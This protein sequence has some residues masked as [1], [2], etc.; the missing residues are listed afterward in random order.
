MEILLK[1]IVNPDNTKTSIY[2][3][4][5]TAPALKHIAGVDQLRYVFALWV[6]FTHGGNP[7]LFAGHAKTPIFDFID[8]LYGWSVNGQ[9]AVMGFFIVS[10]LCIHYPNIRRDSFDIKSFYAARFLRL[11][12]PLFACL[13]IAKFLNFYHPNGFLRVVP[14]W[15]LYCEAIYYVV[16]PFVL[17][18]VKKDY[19]IQL[20]I[21]T[22]FLSVVLI[23]IWS[24][25]RSMYF[26]EIGGGGFLNWKA[27]LL[28][29]PCWLLGVLLAE[30]L[31]VASI[32]NKIVNEK[33]GI[34]LWRTGAL[35]LSVITFPLYRYALYYHFI[36]KPIIGLF[37]TSQLTILL[38]GLY[39]F[40]WIE[41]EVININ[42]GKALPSYRLEKMGAASYSLYL[43]HLLVI[44]LF[45]KI[46]PVYFSGYLSNWLLLFVTLHIAVF[47]F[48]IV[49]EKPSHKL[50]K[51]CAN[52]LRN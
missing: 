33:H 13:A 38:F 29:F 52:A 50:S 32:I 4:K 16:Y 49:F 8:H 48:F 34:W 7:P 42:F 2:K 26:H 1:E 25:Q 12:L 3:R 41:R 21:S 19:L 36:N 9:A 46:S 10:G 11:S 43:V 31:S 5:I 44:W 45:E 37:F 40:F 27:A 18:V 20:I 30:R 14:M 15:T 47:L 51:F 22:G 35:L 23:I 28:A 6:F 24:D 17:W 39:A